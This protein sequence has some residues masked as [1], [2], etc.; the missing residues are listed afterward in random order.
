[1]H[2]VNKLGANNVPWCALQPKT[3]ALSSSIHQ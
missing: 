2:E 3:I 1:M